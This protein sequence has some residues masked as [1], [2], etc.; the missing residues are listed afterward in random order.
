MES[1]RLNWRTSI[2][3]VDFDSN[4]EFLENNGGLYL[5]VLEGNPH[6]VCYVGETIN[7]SDRFLDHFQKLL[8][9]QYTI[10][11]CGLREDLVNFL[12][13]N[14]HDRTIDEINRSDRI[15]IP[16]SSRRET[17]LFDVLIDEKKVR[18]RVEHLHEY[19]FTFA[20][21]EGA[22]V[23]KKC[24]E[25]AL[26]MGLRREYSKLAKVDELRRGDGRRPQIPIGNINKY[27]N[28]EFEIKHVGDGARELPQEL[29]SI[30]GWPLKAD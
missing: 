15:Y 11:N 30:T 8:G 18:R 10:F 29:V 19:R 26:I 7:F 16:T 5:W 12:R 1:V 20:I 13:E 27:P 23:E 3:A 25:A 4:R 28:V 6:R 14:F 21:V 17:R 2:K 24:I 9:G 22:A